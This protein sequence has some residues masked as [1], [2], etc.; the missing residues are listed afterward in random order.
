MKR[1]TEMK[2]WLIT[3]ADKGLG[4]ATAEAALDRGDKFIVTVLAEDGSNPLV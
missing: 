3:G 1:D 4:F 2:T